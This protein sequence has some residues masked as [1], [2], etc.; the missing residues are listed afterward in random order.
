MTEGVELQILLEKD[1]DSTHFTFHVIHETEEYCKQQEKMG[2][3]NGWASTFER[4][5]LHLQEK[6]L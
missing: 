2:F 4:L 5:K 3:Y 1:G 6:T